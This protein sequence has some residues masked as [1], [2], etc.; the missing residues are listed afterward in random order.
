MIKPSELAPATS[1]LISTLLPRYL[2]RKCYRVVVGDS[3]TSKQLLHQKFDYI[4][5]TGS[6]RI[7]RAVHQAAAL[8]LTPTTLELGGKSPLY[9]D[10]SLCPNAYKTACRR[11]IWGKMMNA[12]QTCIAPD[13]VLC[14]QQTR[15]HILKHL[16][17]VIQEFFGEDQKK[18]GDFGRIVNR[19]HFDRLVRLIETCTGKVAYGGH[20]DS[21]ELYISP[22][23]VVDVSPSD[24]IMNE[25]IFGPIFPFIT[26]RDSMEAI[27]FI[28]S[29]PKPLAIYL[30]AQDDHLI[31]RF[32]QDTS[33]GALCVNDVVL[34]C[35]L[36]SLPFGG[37]G[38]SGMGAYHGRYSFDAFSHDKAG[39]MSA[40]SC[41]FKCQLNVFINY[42]C[43]AGSRI[44]FGFGNDQ[45]KKISTLQ[46]RQTTS[47][48]ST[49]EETKL[50]IFYFFVDYFRDGSGF[51]FGSHFVCNALASPQLYSL[52][53]VN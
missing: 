46:Q 47:L 27:E 24:P 37:V 7:G 3:D 52:N 21:E 40:T 34:H 2:D 49:F 22:T 25:E 26:V 8:N 5:F 38:Q 48:T 32:V 20:T 16:I 30:F 45:F 51:R 17:Q 13:Y 15:D 23:I 28:N 42:H 12:G 10:Q 36:D 53:P 33:S 4:F 11:I 35:S 39:K 1:H 9:I 19:N 44:Q 31:E 18:T 6:E 50:S 41:Q 14:N 43:S 29:R